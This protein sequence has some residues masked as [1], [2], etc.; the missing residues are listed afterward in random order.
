MW[1][2][3]KVILDLKIKSCGCMD[4]CM[5]GCMYGWDIKTFIK[6]EDDVVL[7]HLD[8]F[9]KISSPDW[10]LADFGKNLG[11]NVEISKLLLF[12]LK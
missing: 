9:K 2:A 4:G 7:K 10:F 1:R 8:E 5:Y 12:F 6:R 3:V 11:G